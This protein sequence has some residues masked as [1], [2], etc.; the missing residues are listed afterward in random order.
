MDHNTALPPKSS[1]NTE[2]EPLFVRC[3][4]RLRL[5]TRDWYPNVILYTT[6]FMKILCAL[7]KR[8]SVKRKGALFCSARDKAYLPALYRSPAHT[9]KR[10]RPKRVCSCCLVQEKTPEKTFS[11]LPSAYPLHPW[12]IFSAAPPLRVRLQAFSKRGNSSVQLATSDRILV[13]IH[14]R[15]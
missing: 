8:S 1:S 6:F 2:R 10:I 7:T 3:N 13:L 12:L 4:Q 9:L 14:T 5:S 11:N 15:F